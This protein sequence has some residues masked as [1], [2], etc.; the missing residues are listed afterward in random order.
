MDASPAGFVEASRR[1]ARPPRRGGLANVAFVVAAAEDPP[2]ELLGCADAL[3]I[4][5]PWGSL[6]RGALALDEAAA[7]G[8]AAL[9]APGATAAVVL[10]PARRDGLVDLPTATDLLDPHGEAACELRERWYRHGLT[11]DALRAATPA[12]VDATHSTW[13]RG[14]APAAMR[15]GPSPGST[16]A[17]RPQRSTRV[18]HDGVCLR[19]P[20]PATRRPQPAPP[21]R[22]RE[23]H[24]P[25]DQDPRPIH[26]A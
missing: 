2:A 25:P 7:G 3:T 21:A 15:T 6:L 23:S 18:E 13:A 19:A 22:C 20:R 10:A 12:E 26:L 5:F 16:C 24:G 14:F 17:G 9:L 11:V 4:A 8:I 1:A